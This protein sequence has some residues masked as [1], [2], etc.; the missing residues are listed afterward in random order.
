MKDIEGFSSCCGAG[1][2]V[3]K[4]TCLDCREHCS[5]EK[6]S[7]DKKKKPYICGKCE[8][9]MG[10]YPNGQILKK[11]AP[12]CIKRNKC[13]YFN[14]KS[15]R[16]ISIPKYRAETILGKS[17]YCSKHKNKLINN[18]CIK[19]FQKLRLNQ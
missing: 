13:N 15:E 5:V 2:D 9:E 14:K 12:H 16:C 6:E 1:V 10:K 4:L 17:F 11:H 8:Q 7:V 19:N 3:D 18:I